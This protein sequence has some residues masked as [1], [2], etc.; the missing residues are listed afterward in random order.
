MGTMASSLTRRDRDREREAGRER[1]GE[2]G[3]G[4]SSALY[5]S[6]LP[7][8]LGWKVLAEA[9]GPSED[10]VLMDSQGLLPLEELSGRG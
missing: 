6:D 5:S 4:H 7:A 2:G 9:V 1:T 8:T 3:C 10:R